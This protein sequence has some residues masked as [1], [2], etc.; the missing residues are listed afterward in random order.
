M[1]TVSISVDDPGR[2]KTQARSKPRPS[3]KAGVLDRAGRLDPE[4]I[5]GFLE[6]EQALGHSLL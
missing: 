3:D 6:K 5:H 2:V 1:L 4:A